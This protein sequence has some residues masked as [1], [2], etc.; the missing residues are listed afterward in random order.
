MQRVTSIEDGKKV[1]HPMTAT[2]QGTVEKFD[3]LRLK[4]YELT[5]LYEMDY[6][7]NVKILNILP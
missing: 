7:G 4:L 5:T 3:K 6:A 2:H 1:E